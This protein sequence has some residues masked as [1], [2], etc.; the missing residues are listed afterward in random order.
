VA[1]VVAVVPA[2]AAVGV[3]ARAAAAAR[4]NQRPLV[5]HVASASPA[6]AANRAVSAPRDLWLA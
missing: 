3:I 5:Q 1:V 6:V 4:A 2:A